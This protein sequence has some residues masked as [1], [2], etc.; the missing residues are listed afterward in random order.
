[1]AWLSAWVAA[2]IP[3]GFGRKADARQ[4][5]CANPGACYRDH[6]FR[7]FSLRKIASVLSH[8]VVRRLSMKYFIRTASWC[9]PVLAASFGAT[10]AL[11]PGAN[12][13]LFYSTD[14]ITHNVINSPG[15]HALAEYVGLFGSYTGTPIAPNYFLTSK[16]IGVAASLS[17][18]G[19]SY[20]VAAGGLN[21][22]YWDDAASDMRI[23]KI[24]GTFPTGL[25][26]PLFT[27]GSEVGKTL[28]VF[29]RGTQRGAEVNLAG[30][31]VGDL[32]GWFWGASDGKLR[33]GE[34]VVSGFDNFGSN[35]DGLLFARFD[36]N[37]LANEAHLSVGD[38]GGPVFI[39]GKLAGINYAVDGYWRHGSIN[40]GA[41]FEGALF[42]A[43]GLENGSGSTW[44]AITDLA[45]DVPSSFYASRVSDRL[46]WIHT[47]TGVPEPSEWAILAG[48]GLIGFSI[49]RRSRSDEAPGA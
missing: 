6:G 19:D 43:G 5:D 1:M 24:S 32:R 48:L 17:L 25:I 2:R 9:R 22:A 42:D 41:A 40:A 7:E 8:K 29:G 46:G 12:A 14:S 31:S 47:I 10:L 38:S 4:V 33:W 45:N 18:G 26:T 37:G 49:W 35:S 16:H 34:N 30:A 44:N 23:V 3:E 13:V 15:D 39:E 27:T 36:R 11:S 28:T 20:S 21:T